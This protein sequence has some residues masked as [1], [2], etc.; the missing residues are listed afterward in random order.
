[1]KKFIFT[2][3][4]VWVAA[5]ADD[6]QDH[7]TG[8]SATVELVTGTKQKAQ[9][10]GIR[11][12]TVSLGGSIKG[13]FTVVRIP[14]NRFK[15][16]TAED[17]REL[18][19]AS[20]PD[21]TRTGSAPD[22]ANYNNTAQ[23][24]AAADST[25]PNR[26][27]PDSA[28]QDSLSQAPAT[29]QDS[30]AQ[31]TAMPDSSRQDIADVVPTFLDSVKG[32]HIYVALERR[33]SDSALAEQLDN[34]IVKLLKE[35]GTP[36]TYIRQSAVA[37]CTEAACIRDSLRAHGAA[38]LYTGRITA[39]RVPDSLTIQASHYPL[40]D[41][42]T[43][44]ADA[45]AKMNLSAIRSLSD[46]LK[47]DKLSLFVATLQGEKVKPAH[48]SADGKSYIH[49]ETDPDGT[50]IAIHD[51]EDVCH[52]PCTFAT[53]DTGKITLYAYWNVTRQLWGAKATVKPIPGDTVKISLKLKKVKPEIRV[54]TTPDGAEIFAGSA[55]V[56]P[57]TASVGRS[58][59]KFVIYEPGPST[60]QLHKPGYRDTVVSVFASP[61]EI[62][63][64]DIKLT[65]I[66]D[67]REQ[68]TQDEWEHH[69]RMYRFGKTLIGASVTPVL[70]GALFTYLA[71][72]DYDEADKIKN[73]LDQPSSGGPHYQEKV[74]KNRDMVDKGDR[75]MTIGGALIG[76][77]V[78][79]AGIGFVLSF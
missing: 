47:D 6:P 45:T 49:V 65:P 54:S 50:N 72:C 40:G 21:E 8:I 61:T 62:T 37:P 70:L 43:P 1:M 22:S 56:T 77:G 68:T 12:D 53:T 31:E 10:L 24:S 34:L 71:T 79:L 38:S 55:P 13:H 11:N 30:A 5:F 29:E 57:K 51:K 76:A 42:A 52:S 9:F 74:K 44:T 63:D 59:N 75:K 60:I 4:F 16:I 3:L 17:G 41:S 58:P 7:P 28:K 36:I 64:I 73:E 2:L 32:K 67:I 20:A 25:A 66:T 18:L 33:N 19:K 14:A 46:A 23:I 39:S 48:A 15:S 27:V 78:I 26:T 69:R 35:S